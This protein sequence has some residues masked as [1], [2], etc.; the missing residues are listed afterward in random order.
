MASYKISLIC[1][2]KFP[3][4]SLVFYYLFL[5]SALRLM[6]YLQSFSIFLSFFFNIFSSSSFWESLGYSDLDLFRVVSLTSSDKSRVGISK[7]TFLISLPFFFSKFNLILSIFTYR[8]A[9]I[10]K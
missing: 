3:P 6:I 5:D 4:Y 8:I 10:M 9:F 2:K 1:T 7:G